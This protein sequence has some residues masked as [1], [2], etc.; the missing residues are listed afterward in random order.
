MAYR[1]GLRALACD[2][3]GYRP[4]CAAVLN[5]AAPDLLERTLPASSP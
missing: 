4:C 2:V 5:D 3:F 1:V